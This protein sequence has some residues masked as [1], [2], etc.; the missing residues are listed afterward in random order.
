MKIKTITYTERKVLAQYEYAELTSVAELA[1]GENEVDAVIKLM[2]YVTASLNK[3]ISKLSEEKTNGKVSGKCNDNSSNDGGNSQE[4]QIKKED[5]A[6]KKTKKRIEK[7][8]T[9]ITDKSI[10]GSEIAQS[11]GKNVVIYNSAIPE[12]KSILGGYL[13]KKYDN[14]WKTAKPAAEIKEFTASL[15]SQEFVDVDGKIVDSFLEKIHGFFGA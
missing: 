9:S 1:E 5:K 6:D 13:S 4:E 8:G 3:E 7:K 2:A 14:A 15:N 10:I 12:H 11:I